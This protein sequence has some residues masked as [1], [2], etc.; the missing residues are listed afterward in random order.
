MVIEKN[1]E[2]YQKELRKFMKIKAKIKIIVRDNFF[3]THDVVWNCFDF[4]YWTSYKVNQ[5]GLYTNNYHV[6]FMSDRFNEFFRK[7]R[8]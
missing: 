4:G 1:V 5:Y 7:A 2:T 8:Q 6:D 3:H